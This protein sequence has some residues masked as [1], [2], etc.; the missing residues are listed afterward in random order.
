MTAEPDSGRDIVVIAASEGG[1][2]TLRVILGTLPATLPAA[3]FIVLHIGALPS[4]LPE[5]LSGASPLPI[6]HARDGEAFE[7]GRVYIAPPDNHMLLEHRGIRLSRGPKEN[8]TR[9]AAD[10]LFR[11][12]AAA[13]GPRVIGIVLTGGDADGTKGLREIKARGGIAIVQTPEDA[14]VPQMPANAIAG[15]H[16]DYCVPAKEIGPLL[17]KLVGQPAQA[18]Q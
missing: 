18:A 1:I 4:T 13:Y 17:A 5:T 3:L 12:A 14:K 16:P 9:P 6:A 11:S 2:Q 15:D 10:P 8:F 7:R